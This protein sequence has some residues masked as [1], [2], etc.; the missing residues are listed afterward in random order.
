M[1]RLCIIVAALVLTFGLSQCKKTE[2]PTT[3][4]GVRITLTAT[5]GGEKTAFTPEYG[6]FTWTGTAGNPEYINVGGSTS[7]YLGQL[8]STQSGATV[9]FS[10][11]INPA[12]G[13][14]LYFFYLGNG[15]HAS[16]TTLDFSNQDGTLDNVT[17]YHIAISDGIEYTGQSNFTATLNMKMAIAYFD[18]SG[19]KKADET[20]ETVYLHGDEVYTTATVNYQDGTISGTTKGYLNMGTATAGKY[21]ALIPSVET[22]TE[23]KF[24]SDS[25]TGTMRFVNGIRAGKYYVN[26][27]E[28]L[29]VTAN[30]LLE[31]T[32]PGLFS[33]SATKMV[34]FSKGN[35]QY[36]GSATTPYWKF[37][38]NQW[39]YLGTTT[40]QDSESETVDRDLFCWGTSGWNNGNLLY[41]PYNTKNTNNSSIGYGYGPYDGSTYIIDLTGSYANA[42]WGVYNAISNGG[43]EQNLWRT[44]T[45][46]EWVHVC[47]NRSTLSNIRYVMGNVS[48]VNGVILLPNDWRTTVHTLTLGGNC[49]SNTISSSDWEVMEVNGA[50]FLPAAGYRGGISVSN[51]GES[52]YYWSSTCISYDVKLVK[53]AYFVSNN[54]GVD[55]FYGTYRNMGASVRLVCDVD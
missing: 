45:V 8:T 27:T 30:S 9:S 51:L 53:S 16:A 20:A 36:I 3:N 26:G 54:N 39:I 4:E 47:K 44:L 10:G 7:G 25:K 6:T 18:V 19:F 48:G 5:Y 32:I 33:V 37:A 24:D 35:L 49:A 50:V 34:R 29:N 23:L 43:N 40:G 13:E 28:A 11:T 12:S 52:G 42:D 22:A 38:D 55:P 17:N 31:G 1:K 15:D 46:E 14:T 2:T 21:V 41:Q